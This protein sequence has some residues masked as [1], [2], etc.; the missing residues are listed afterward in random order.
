MLQLSRG[1]QN[2]KHMNKYKVLK[3]EFD[4][5]KEGEVFRTNYTR[6]VK[7]A[8]KQGILEECDVEIPTT[9]A[10]QDD[11][12]SS[13][14]EELGNLQD[15]NTRLKDDNEAKDKTI[16]DL[17]GKLEAQE[18]AGAE[19]TEKIL[20]LEKANTELG[21]ELQMTKDELTAKE[22][23]LAAAQLEI[24]ELKKKKK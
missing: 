23:E 14:Q 17:A 24:E 13:L 9:K 10:I 4:G 19:G 8:I 18:S 21:T 7:L 1:I 22:K 5:H 6:S 16:N 20:A 2:P 3:G 11:K 15:E 12:T